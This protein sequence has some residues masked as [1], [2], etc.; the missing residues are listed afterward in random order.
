MRPEPPANYRTSVVEHP[1]LRQR[2]THATRMVLR[3]IERNPWRAFASVIGIA[4]AIGI[5]LFGF[6]FLDAMELVADLQ[7][8]LVQRQDVTVSFVEPV[9]SRARHEI[10]SLPGVLTVEPFRSVPVRLRHGHRYRNLAVM[11][12]PA[13]RPT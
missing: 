2:L 10:A 9:S 8:T 5:L 12:M 7:F 3:N 6:V 1:R 4:F 13:D 11:G